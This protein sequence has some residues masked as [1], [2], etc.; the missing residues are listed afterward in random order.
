MIEPKTK[1]VSFSG[2]GGSGKTTT[3]T[4]FLYAALQSGQFKKILVIDADPDTN[5]TNTL[6]L[7]PAMTVGEA[8]DRQ[9]RSR[10][11][12][13]SGG[14]K[15][16]VLPAEVIC[17]ANGFDFVVMGRSR[18]V[19]CYCSVTAVL[20]ELLGK[21]MDAYELVIIDYD[22]GLEHISRKAG[23]TVGTLI[24]TCDPSKL[25]FETA[26]RIERLLQE[27]QAGFTGKFIIG[28]RYLEEH[29]AVYEKLAAKTGFVSLGIVPLDREVAAKNLQ[30]ESL[31]TLAQS[32]QAVMIV[33]NM[34]RDLHRTDRGSMLPES[35][36]HQSPVGKIME[37]ADKR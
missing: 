18:G 5:M 23:G 30:R 31:L 11:E 17:Q 35:E 32:N 6:Q 14:G 9:K 4:L 2:K 3:A 33:G 29:K 16:A 27:I 22:A 12:N 19:G 36:E 28:C 25:S 24:V 1:I 34:F 15:L 26:E 10:E 7:S 21:T 37:S 20:N 13:G 8:L